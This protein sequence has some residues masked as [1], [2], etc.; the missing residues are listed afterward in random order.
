MTHLSS[1]LPLKNSLSLAVSSIALLAMAPVVCAQEDRAAS[2]Q[3]LTIPEGSLGRSLLDVSNTFGVPILA[4]E[5]LVSGKRSPAISGTLSASEAID[6]LLDGSDLIALPS[7]NGGFIIQERPAA[8]QSAPAAESVQQS[9][10]SDLE[11][12][13][14]E[15][16]VVI[17][18]QFQ[19]SLVNRLPVPEYE[20]S[21]TL[22]VIDQSILVDR[23]FIDVQES[24]LTL[25]NVTAFGGNF[26]GGDFFVFSRG[27]PGDFLVNNRPYFQNRGSAF[28]RS[29]VDRL[30]V[31]KG[32]STIA[33]GPVF[34]GGIFNTVLK[35]PMR[36]DAYEVSVIANTFGSLRGEA[37][38]NA[39]QLFG[40]DW[41]RGR[42]NVAYEDGEGKANRISRERFNIRPIIEADLSP[43]TRVQAAVLYSEIDGSFQPSFPLNT[44]LSIPQEITP[45]TF[46]GSQTNSGRTERVY[47]EAQV[48]HD[49]LDNLKLTLR[50]SYTDEDNDAS[51]GNGFYAYNYYY[52]NGGLYGLPPGDRTGY[53]YG[54]VR[55]ATNEE[56]YGDAQLATHFELFGIRQDALIGATYSSQ[57]LFNS[58]FLTEV[59]GV[60]DL[61]NSSTFLLPEITISLPDDPDGRKNKDELSSVY[62]EVY[63]RPTDRLTIPFGVRYDDVRQERAL[64]A[65]GTPEVQT[66]SDVTIKTGVNFEVMDGLRVYYA[67]AESFIPQISLSRTGFLD[68]ETGTMHEI[69]VKYRGSNGLSIDAA[70]FDITREGL[71][72]PDPNNGPGE[73]FFV[74]EGAQES[75]GIEISVSG[76]LTDTISVNVNYGYVDA[77]ITEQIF[78]QIGRIARVPDHSGSAYIKY[79]PST[80]PLSKF[81]SSAGV[82]HVSERPLRSPNIADPSAPIPFVDGYTIAEFMVGYQLTENIDLQANVFNVF[83]KKY[84]E[85][86]GFGSA[87]GGFSFGEPLNAQLTLRAKF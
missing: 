35:E 86:L 45:G 82:R 52:Y 28:D 18:S 66:E 27:F 1:R 60:V 7:D 69:G 72:V 37:D 61:A 74:A 17:T 12:P 80:G 39:G 23:N 84:L 24:L 51:Y 75:K 43:N 58:A 44:D 55:G 42:L 67:Y 5:N 71:A 85:D 15:D 54:F 77:E 31:L 21:A 79:D 46:I 63:L 32:P 49:F 11:E 78:G 38:L 33:F 34:P 41:L 81:R 36:D 10:V 76:D 6:T 20:V 56:Y 25:P 70:I 8:P 50:G 83:D 4:P 59:L 47:A 62:A 19:N 48:V 57:D 22:N 14:I 73:G 53:A 3:S 65:G 9:D 87:G 30:E 64:T 16:I 13:R 26:A 29:V 2:V 68:S 40:Q